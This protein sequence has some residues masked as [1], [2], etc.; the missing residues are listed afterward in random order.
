MPKISSYVINTTPEATDILIGTDVTNGQTKNFTV[1]SLSGVALNLYLKQTNWQFISTDPSP[2]ERPYGSLSFQNYGGDGTAWSSISSMYINTRMPSN[3]VVSLPFLQRLVGENI[4]IQD[5]RASA[6]F[7]VY[8][9]NSLTLVSDDIYDMSLTYVSGNSTLARLKYYSIQYDEASN[10]SD[11]H[12]VFTQAN[13]SAQ[14]TI[15]HNLNKYPSVAVVNN[16]DIV[17]NG[18]IEYTSLNELTATFSGGFSGKAY[19]N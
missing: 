8:K 3:P 9:L 4:I 7:G 14:W 16:N 19:L 2:S 18:E 15:V 1:D 17:V 13:P 12:F 11:K 10:V 6:R 5:V